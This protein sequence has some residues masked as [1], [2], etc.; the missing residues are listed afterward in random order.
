MHPALAAG[1]GFPHGR[2]LWR[3]TMT[4]AMKWVASEEHDLR[5]L[6]TP[7]EIHSLPNVQRFERVR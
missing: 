4:R 7:A 3:S 1:I 5:R 2:V 6:G